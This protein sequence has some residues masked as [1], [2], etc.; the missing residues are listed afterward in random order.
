MNIARLSSV[1]AFKAPQKAKKSSP[2]AETNQVDNGDKVDLSGDK[3]CKEGKKGKKGKKNKKCKKG[4]K[5]GEGPKPPAGWDNPDQYRIRPGQ[6]FSMCEMATAPPEGIPDDDT[7]KAML[8]EVQGDIIPLAEKLNIEDRRAL[9]VVLQGMDAS[10][11]GGIVEH[12]LSGSAVIEEDGKEKEHNF[13]SAWRH[14]ASFGKPTKAEWLHPKGFIGRV[15]EERPPAGR[16][17]TF[18]RSHYEDL[19]TVEVENLP[20]MHAGEKIE[21]GTERWYEVLDSRV[22]LV[23]NYENGWREGV[24]D[25]DPEVAPVPTHSIKIFAHQSWDVQ[26]AELQERR[27]KE[28]AF[29]KVKKGDVEIHNDPVRYNNYQNKWA[30]VIGKTSTEEAPWYVLPSENRHY[31]RLMAAKI[32]LGELQSMNPQYASLPDMD[33]SWNLIGEPPENLNC[34]YSRS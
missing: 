31:Q 8:S 4:D 11:K 6:E 9:L 30:E 7:L 21:A 12:V 20:L 18:D 34:P 17:G 32:I 33:P 15:A 13:S 2:K 28:R 23:K 10:G 25:S 26:T 16:I 24:V 1:Q 27:E 14:A 29:H 22:D 3:K 19:V 5:G